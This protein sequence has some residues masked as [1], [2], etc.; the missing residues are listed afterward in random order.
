MFNMCHSHF[1]SNLWCPPVMQTGIFYS[2]FYLSRP[3]RSGPRGL[4]QPGA[5]PMLPA[6]VREDDGSLRRSSAPVRLVDPGGP[7]QGGPALGVVGT[8]VGGAIHAAFREPAGWQRDPA[9][10]RKMAKKNETNPTRLQPK[11]LR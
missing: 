10:T 8:R 2:V 6:S 5:G 9:S 3:S 7:A 1:F 4:L 11:V